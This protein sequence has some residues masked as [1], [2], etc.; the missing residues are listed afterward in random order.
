MGCRN[1]A[2]AN[3]VRIDLAREAARIHISASP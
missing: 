2:A 1:V 3:F